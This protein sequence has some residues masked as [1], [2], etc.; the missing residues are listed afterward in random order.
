MFHFDIVYLTRKPT[1]VYGISNTQVVHLN[2]SFALR[3][4]CLIV[5]KKNRVTL[6]VPIYAVF[7][8]IYH[9]GDI[10]LVTEYTNTNIM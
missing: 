4:L 7:S 3:L 9:P 5:L 2:T 10:F 8:F 6:D 1:I